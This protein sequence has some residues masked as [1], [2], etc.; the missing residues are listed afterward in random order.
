MSGCLWR[1][2]TVP[3]ILQDSLQLP[4][5]ACKAGRCMSHEIM[6]FKVLHAGAPQ[7]QC[8]RQENQ[9]QGSMVWVDWA[10]T[11]WLPLKTRVDNMEYNTRAL[12]N[13]YTTFYPDRSLAV[14][15]TS[16]CFFQA[17]FLAMPA[18]AGP[19]GPPCATACGTAPVTRSVLV[20][21]HQARLGCQGCPSHA[22]RNPEQGGYKASK[23]KQESLGKA[24]VLQ[25]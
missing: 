15:S 20:P 19:A 11:L 7:H 24:I 3:E 12:N 5:A 16:S 1:W 21:C 2:A 9:C 10:L 14:V 17:G 13:W 6:P 4:S 22:A 18:R 25:P 8:R 23:S